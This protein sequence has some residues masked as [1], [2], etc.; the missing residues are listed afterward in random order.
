MEIVFGSIMV[1]GVGYLL[2]MVFGLA[3]N[4]ELFDVDGALGLDAGMDGM[5]CALIAVFMAVFGAFGLT[6][7]LLGWNLFG[8]ILTAVA[9]GL[10]LSRLGLAALRQLRRQESKPIAFAHTD[11]IGR[12]A[13]ITIASAPGKTGEVLV[14]AHTILKYPVREING[15]ALQRGDRVTIVDVEGRFLVVRKI[16]SL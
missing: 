8:T 12:N 16:A 6:G 10:V 13:K 9:L 4:L 1:V 5:G 14:E 7:V 2:L 3:D 15:E 11:L